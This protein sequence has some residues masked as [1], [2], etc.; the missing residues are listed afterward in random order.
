MKY[1]KVNQLET[2]TFITNILLETLGTVVMLICPGEMISS[3]SP[4][5]LYFDS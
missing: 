1:L 5:P 4:P 3:K 2:T